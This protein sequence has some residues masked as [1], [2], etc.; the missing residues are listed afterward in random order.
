MA[1]L[2]WIRR[3]LESDKKFKSDY[4]DFMNNL[5]T[6]AFS[7]KIPNDELLGKQGCVWYI[8]HHGVYHPKKPGKI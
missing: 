2:K 4:V 3:K 6:K 5:T 8:P 7:R 1:R